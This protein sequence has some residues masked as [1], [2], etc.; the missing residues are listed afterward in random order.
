VVKFNSEAQVMQ[1]LASLQVVQVDP[2]DKH[3]P[4]AKYYKEGHPGVQRSPF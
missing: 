3:F 2:Q 1:V 4:S